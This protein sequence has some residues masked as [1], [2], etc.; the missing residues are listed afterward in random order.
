MRQGGRRAL[1]IKHTAV[2]AAR[3]AQHRHATRLRC[4]QRRIEAVMQ[5]AIAG[6][7]R[8]DAL[9][10]ASAQRIHQRVTG[11]RVAVHDLDLRPRGRVGGQMLQADRRPLRP[12]PVLPN[13][14]FFDVRQYAGI[15]RAE[16]VEPVGVDLAHVVCAMH[17]ARQHRHHA[18]R[19]GV[20]RHAHGVEQVLRPVGLRTGG[21]AHGGRQHH[22]LGGCEHALQEPRGLFE[23]VGAVGDDD[24]R[25]LGARQVVGH[26]LSQCQPHRMR[27]VLAVDLRHLFGFERPAGERRDRRHQ[28]GHADLRGGIADVVA[29]ARR[30]AGD[31]AAGAEDHNGR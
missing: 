29:C 16:R 25:H 9:H 14:A 8:N 10:P 31:G 18:V 6:A 3:A 11:V 4:L 19:T 21:R 28:R 1:R 15:A 22:R 26:A 7:R 23:R 12:R 17:R 24:A 5:A 20:L 2:E 30:R 27:H 13:H